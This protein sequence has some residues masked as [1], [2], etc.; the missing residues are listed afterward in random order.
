MKDESVVEHYRRSGG[1]FDRVLDRLAAAGI[2][3]ESMTE[4]DLSGVDEFHA[5]GRPATLAVVDALALDAGARVVDLGCGVGGPG[6]TMAA[7]GHEVVGV[8]LMP[9]F[10]DL[11]TRLTVLVGLDDL[12]T[13]EVGDAAATRFADGS[14]DGATIF[15]VGMNIED[16]RALAAEIAR[17]L[18]PGGRAAVYDMMR[19]GEG[20]LT[21]PVPWAASPAASHVET[22]DAYAEALTHAGLVV[23]RTESFAPRLPEFRAGAADAPPGLDLSVLMGEDFPAMFANMIGALGA[24]LIAPTLVVAEAPA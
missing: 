22:S 10:V 6:R 14:F 15:H 4:S 17:L 1:L 13:F 8:D 23:E 18:R 21:Y 16:K 19:T 2:S 9:E 12:A 7:L 5:G 24:G 3:P 20:E 11:A